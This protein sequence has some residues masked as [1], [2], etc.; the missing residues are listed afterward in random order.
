[1]SEYFY[2]YIGKDCISI[3]I[4][5]TYPKI[6]SVG[7]RIKEI[8]NYYYEEDYLNISTWKAF[9]NNYLRL[10]APEIYEKLKVIPASEHSVMYCAYIEGVNEET[11]GLADKFVSIFDDLIKNED[12]AY[13]F[14]EQNVGDIDWDCCATVKKAK[15]EAV[16]PYF[17]CDY[18]LYGLYLGDPGKFTVSMNGDYPTGPRRTGDD[19]GYLIELNHNNHGV[20]HPIVFQITSTGPDTV[21]VQGGLSGTDYVEADM[22]ADSAIKLLLAF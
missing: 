22:D 16:A 7:E 13:S 3:N 5:F 17:V 8:S 4:D 1:M 10:N 12:K 21:Y 2:A 19:S 6:S 14:L 20:E 15:I 9:L 11:K 18:V